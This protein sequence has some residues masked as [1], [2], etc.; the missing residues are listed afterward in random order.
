M[1]NIE[2]IL[3]K[4]ISSYHL[5]L[6]PIMMFLSG[7]LVG[8][9][10]SNLFK[11]RGQ[12][13][14]D[15]LTHVNQQTLTAIQAS[16]NFSR[17][18]ISRAESLTNVLQGDVRAQGTWGELKL[19]RILEKSGLKE[20]DEFKTQKKYKSVPSGSELQPDCVIFL[21]E[22]RHVIIDSKVSLK[23]YQ[24]YE[25]A[26]SKKEKEQSR[27]ELVKDLKKHVGDLADKGYTNLEG[28]DTAE[29]ILMFVPF[30][31]A[32]SLV[33]EAK[34]N[35]S[36]EDLL[37][38]AFERGIILVSPSSLFAV[39]KSVNLIWRKIEQ[40]ENTEKIVE[41][42]AKMHDQFTDFLEEMGKI[43]SS[44]NS[45]KAAHEKAM[46][47]L[48]GQQGAISQAKQVENLGIQPKRPLSSR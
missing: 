18:L 20:G 42:A 4:M 35:Q 44:L 15:A 2:E 8:V 19:S 6:F 1:N 48:Q 32:L 13:S 28:L 16:E 26:K 46:I 17:Q 38:Y 34:V 3:E 27:K 30:E 11:S 5:W 36:Q 31:G 41:R 33:S 24:A 29:F 10:V 22:N 14:I 45:A 39:L 47:K 9:V 23:N 37:K 12:K 21:P 25:E 7:I 43:N 40:S